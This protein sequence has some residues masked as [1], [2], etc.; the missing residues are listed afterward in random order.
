MYCTAIQKNDVIITRTIIMTVKPLITLE[1]GQPAPAIVTKD[2]FNNPIELSS[3]THRFAL[4]AFM[5]YSDCPWCN[6]A[7]HRLALEYKT[8]LEHDCEI[9]AFIQSDAKSITENIHDRH[10]VKPEFPIIADPECIFYE[11]YG[12]R[13]DVKA[14]YD[15]WSAFPGTS[16]LPHRHAHKYNRIRRLRKKLL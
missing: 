4:L 1:V 7:I 14:T 16:L 5:R 3:S 9:I 11:Q 15:R 2:V 6:L 12:V 8:F 10:A 13:S